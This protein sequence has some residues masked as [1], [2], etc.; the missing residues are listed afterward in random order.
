MAVH[1][2]KPFPDS[3]DEIAE[4]ATAIKDPSYRVQ[5]SQDGI[6][7][8]N[9]DGHHVARDPFDI[10]PNLGLDADGGHAFYMGVETARAQ[11]AWQLGKRHVQDEELDWGCA[12]DRKPD[13]KLGHCA[14][15]TTLEARPL[16]DQSQ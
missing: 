5:V 11:I 16:K 3:P 2:R 1:A 9:R 14:P 7:V 4:T 10:W 13:D 15:G 8:Y 6:H 12:V